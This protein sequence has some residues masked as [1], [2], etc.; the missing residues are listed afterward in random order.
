MGFA[1][2]NCGGFCVKA[3]QAHFVTLFKAMP[4]RYAYHERK[5]Q[6]IRALLGDVS[7]LRDRRGDGE[8]KPL[9]LQALRERYEAG[10]QIDMFD[11]G[12]CGCFVDQEPPPRPEEER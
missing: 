2:N 1:H 6:E 12:G 11:I 3:G 8:T 7:I 9:T 10:G 5:E 4:E